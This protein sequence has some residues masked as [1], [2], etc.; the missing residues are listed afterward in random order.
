LASLSLNI[1]ASFDSF[2]GANPLGKE[3]IFIV[4]QV[5]IMLCNVISSP[6]L[7]SLSSLSLD[8][9]D[10]VFHCTKQKISQLD[11]KNIQDFLQNTKTMHDLLDTIIKLP[12]L[13]H[14][15]IKTEGMKIQGIN[16][17][18]KKKFIE[19]MNKKIEIIKLTVKRNL[20][21]YSAKNRIA[22]VEDV[23]SKNLDTKVYYLNIDYPMDWQSN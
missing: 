8:V 9:S 19:R 10:L 14:F 4:N 16:E 6:S 5:T 23:L 21:Q 13:L 12:N 11:P 7:Q 3:D 17:Q 18:D 1:S 15:D 22:V 20:S 2:F